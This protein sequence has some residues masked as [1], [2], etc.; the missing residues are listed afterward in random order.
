MYIPLYDSIYFDD[1]YFSNL[2][3]LIEHFPLHHIIICGDVI[4]RIPIIKHVINPDQ[5]LNINGKKLI[6]VLKDNKNL[7]IAN[8]LISSQV[9]FDSSYTFYRGEWKSQ[10]DFVFA[11]NIDSITLFKILD[12]NIY[13]DLVQESSIRQLMLICISLTDVQKGT[14]DCYDINKRSRNP[15]NWRRVYV[16]KMTHLMVQDAHRIMI[17]LHNADDVIKINKVSNQKSNVIYNACKNSYKAKKIVV[18]L[19]Q[20]LLIV[21]LLITTPSLKSIY[22]HTIIKL[23]TTYRANYAIHIFKIG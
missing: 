10:V 6:N 15:I 8:G 12:K 4:H 22:I 7:V 17:V 21:R 16:I 18:K 1:I 23:L 11:N 2:R 5:V 9:T 19:L 20:I 14:F 3:L 13:S